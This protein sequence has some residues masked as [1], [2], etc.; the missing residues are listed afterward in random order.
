MILIFFKHDALIDIV[1]PGIYASF[2]NENYKYH[3]EHFDP[4]DLSC[5]HTLRNIT[6]CIPNYGPSES[7]KNPMTWISTTLRT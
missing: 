2:T 1:T 3:G 6:V 7:P 4:L 5:L